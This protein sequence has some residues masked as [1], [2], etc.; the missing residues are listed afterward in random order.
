[1]R[2]WAP[3]ALARL[4]FP[5]GSTATSVTAPGV[6]PPESRCGTTRFPC[7]AP[8]SASAGG[9]TAAPLSSVGPVTA[10]DAPATG[11]AAASCEPG[12]VWSAGAPGDGA[13]ELLVP[14]TG[15][16]PGS[17]EDGEDAHPVPLEA[18]DPLG[19][20]DPLEAGFVPLGGP[21]AAY[22][23]PPGGVAGEPLRE[24]GAEDEP[25]GA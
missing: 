24:P 5:V 20:G 9:G 8:A 1:V 17:V 7:V 10:A 16:V 12:L 3:F 6:R 19:A 14:G 2:R 4:K 23:A 13:G 22:P 15:L 11:P 25:Q 18:G 21:L